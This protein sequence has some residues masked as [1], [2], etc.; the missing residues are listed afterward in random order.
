MSIKL[1]PGTAAYSDR[2]PPP[3]QH[4]VWSLVVGSIALLIGG[5]GLLNWLAGAL[6]WWIPPNVEQ[7]LGRIVLPAYE[8]MAQPSATQET[9]N[10]LLNRFQPQ[11]TV[12]QQ[13]RDYQILY[14]PESTVNA[15]ALPGDH[16][17]IFKGLLQAVESENELMMILGHELGHFAHRDHLRGL[18]RNLLMQIVVAT[19]IGDASGLQAL[20]VSGAAQVSQA[21]YSQSQEREADESGLT[22][23]QA[24]YGHVAGATDFFARMASQ[25]SLDWAFLTTHPAPR[26]RVA[27]LERLIRTQR[28]PIRA[29]SPLPKTLNL[30]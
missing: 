5:I 15:F 14:V 29:R 8:R 27:H 19:V 21:Q 4:H 7:Q 13:Q 16:I 3:S 26:D 6:V 25:S 10:Q 20:L 30:S 28:Y 11:L 18:S 23:L 9:L 24:V 1:P 22:L 12:E 2:N 17:V